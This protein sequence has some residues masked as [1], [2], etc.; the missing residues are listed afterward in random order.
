MF[1]SVKKK[2]EIGGDTGVEA[3]AGFEMM[4]GEAGD[5][6]GTDAASSED[7]AVGLV[8]ENPLHKTSASAQIF[9]A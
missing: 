3:A 2:N 8:T 7:H 6:T 9:S 5:G 4:Q 1:W